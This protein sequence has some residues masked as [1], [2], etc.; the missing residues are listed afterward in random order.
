V[1]ESACLSIEVRMLQKFQ[2]SDSDG[3]GDR[4]WAMGIEYME[5]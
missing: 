5:K 2:H 1:L 4:R 3:E